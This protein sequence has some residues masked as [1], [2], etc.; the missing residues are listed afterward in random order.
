MPVFSF[1]LRVN[2][3]TVN[4][5]RPRE[6]ELSEQKPLPAT[7]THPG[8]GG[9]RGEGGAAPPELLYHLPT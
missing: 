6:E 5:K 1:V 3:D 9:G 4:P 2:P 7:W 8:C